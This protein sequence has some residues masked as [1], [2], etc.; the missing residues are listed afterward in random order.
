MVL[1]HFSRT[2]FAWILGGVLA[3]VIYVSGRYPKSEK[4]SPKTPLLFRVIGWPFAIGG[5][6][7]Y[8]M[9]RAETK[10]KAKRK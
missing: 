9:E 6:V 5:W 3:I 8:R 10:R 1:A 2:L 7:K 4:Y